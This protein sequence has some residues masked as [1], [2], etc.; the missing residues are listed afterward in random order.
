MTLNKISLKNARL[1][2]V[3]DWKELVMKITGVCLCP[4]AGVL[5]AFIDLEVKYKQISILTLKPDC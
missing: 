5:N 1:V 2:I 3:I 4:H